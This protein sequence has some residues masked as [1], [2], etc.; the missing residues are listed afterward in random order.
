MKYLQ[1]NGACFFG[2]RGLEIK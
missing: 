2:G 1:E